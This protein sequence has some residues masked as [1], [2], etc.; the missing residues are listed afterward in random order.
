MGIG[1]GLGG[2]GGGGEELQGLEYCAKCP[3]FFHVGEED[4]RSGLS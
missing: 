3:E 4:N 2:G 1:K